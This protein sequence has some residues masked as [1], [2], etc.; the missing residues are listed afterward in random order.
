[1]R[2]VYVLPAKP[3]WWYSLISCC[4]W[5]TVAL[6][7]LSSLSIRFNVSLSILSISPVVVSSVA[8]PIRCPFV[9]TIS[10][11]GTHEKGYQ[12]YLIIIFLPTQKLLRISN[13]YL[14]SLILSPMSWFIC[15]L[16]PKWSRFLTCSSIISRFLICLCPTPGTTELFIIFSTM[17][18][19]WSRSLLSWQTVSSHSWKQGW[20]WTHVG[21]MPMKPR[22]HSSHCFPAIPSLHSHFP[23]ILSHWAISE[24]SRWQLHSKCMRREEKEDEG[25]EDWTRK[26]H[27]YILQHFTFQNL[28]CLWHM[29]TYLCFAFV[30]LCIYILL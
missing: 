12:K 22:A 14:R 24:P 1:M 17:S 21:K 29:T 28:V 26:K 23:V 15:C 20:Q 25:V 16:S 2:R 8:T 5:A 7:S 6:M 13:N 11:L 4:L 10:A 9:R 3:E 30:C 19:M 18:F 27:Q